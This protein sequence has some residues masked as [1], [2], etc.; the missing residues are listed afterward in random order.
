M[1][2]RLTKSEMFDLLAD[3]LAKFEADMTTGRINWCTKALERMFGYKIAGDLEGKPVEVLI[4]TSLRENHAKV[5][6]PSFVADPEVRMMGR[7]LKLH[8][9][10]QDGTVFPVEVMLIPRAVEGVR[11]V[12]GIVV[13]MTGREGS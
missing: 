13:D 4:P 11:V 10:R 1:T 9:Q 7:Q 8:G 6:R 3:H 5:H 2:M 12:V